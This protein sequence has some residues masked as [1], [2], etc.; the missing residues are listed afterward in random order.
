[1]IITYALAGLILLVMTLGLFNR[2]SRMAVIS[3]IPLAATLWFSVQTKIPDW[4]GYPVPV[5][6]ISDYADQFILHGVQGPDAIYLLVLAEGAKEPRLLALENTEA[7]QKVMKEFQQNKRMGRATAV[8]KAGKGKDNRQ[9]NDVEI[10]PM[11]EQFV[12]GKDEQ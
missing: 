8:R 9:V 2:W 11:R 10:V 6:M 7:N 4:L 12:P 1:M 5:T 3:L